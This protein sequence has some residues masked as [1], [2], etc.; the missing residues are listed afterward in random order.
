MNMLDI[1]IL[2][3]LILGG[4]IGFREEFT[5]SLVNF[6]GYIIIIVLAFILKNPIAEFL[7]L[8]FPF[9]DFYGVIKG[10][11]VLNI[12]VYEVIAFSVVFFLLIIILKVLQIFTS[13]FEKLLSLTIVLGI[14]SKILG[15]IIGVLKNYV[16][17]F[18]ILFILSLPNFS[19]HSIIKD[20]SFRTPILGNTP[21]LSMFASKTI[22]VFDEFSLLK[23]KYKNTSSSNNFNYETLDLFLKYG[24]VK[25][26]LVLK[27]SNED[28]L[29]IKGVSKL[30]EKY[31]E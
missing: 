3:F 2:L 10:V 22:K 23:D 31:K 5:K 4:I 18:V 12:L 29:H 11:S 9:F 26:D 15:M 25:P 8:H 16:L 28:K 17:V 21:I 14:P 30:I 6:L 1:S 13:I 20:S 19:S 27:L 24:I 7:M